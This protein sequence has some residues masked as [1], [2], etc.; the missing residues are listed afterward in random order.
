MG[1]PKLKKAPMGTRVP[2]DN[3]Q[4][5]W[6]RDAHYLKYPWWYLAMVDLSTICLLLGSL[7]WFWMISIYTL[8]SIFQMC[9]IH[10][11]ITPFCH[12]WIKNVNIVTYG[13]GHQYGHD[14][15]EELLRSSCQQ[16]LLLPISVFNNHIPTKWAALANQLWLTLNC[17]LLCKTTCAD[18]KLARPGWTSYQLLMQ[19]QHD[20]PG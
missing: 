7:T 17:G 14:W 3:D 5:M 9:T 10:P 16:F 18:W 2:T 20:Q 6:N 4:L 15:T 11:Q 8:I 1:T 13:V 19:G 12:H